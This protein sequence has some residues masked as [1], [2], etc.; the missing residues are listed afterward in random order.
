MTVSELAFAYPLG[1]QVISWDELLPVSPSPALSESQ[2][3]QFSIVDTHLENRSSYKQQ[4]SRN[5]LQRSDTQ[6]VSTCR[7]DDHV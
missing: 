5:A 3:S 1:N 6:H 2:R 4:N 7:S